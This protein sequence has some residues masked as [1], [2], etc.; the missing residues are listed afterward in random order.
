MDAEAFENIS[1]DDEPWL[2]DYNV[3]D[4]VIS[5]YVESDDDM[6]IVRNA[7]VD[8]KEALAGFIY[9]CCQKTTMRND[10]LWDA[11]DNLIQR[12]STAARAVLNGGNLDLLRILAD[13]QTSAEEKKRL[14]VRVRED[15]ASLVPVL[16]RTL[17]SLHD[18]T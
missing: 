8:V 3:C 10:I 11:D 18:C 13:G 15:L 1:D 6:P 4:D 9:I 2:P 7:H 14:I 12:M 5:T 16:A 17:V